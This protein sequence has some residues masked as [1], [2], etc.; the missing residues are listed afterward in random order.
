MCRRFGTLCSIFIGGVYV[1]TFRNAL[2]V[3]SSQAVFICRRFGTL[4]SIFIGGVYVPTFRNALS[5][6]SSQAVFICRRLGTL[7]SIFIGG[8]YVPTFRNTLFH[9]HRRCLYADVSEHSVLSLQLVL[10][11]R[12]FC[13]KLN[14]SL[15][16]DM[17][18]LA[19]QIRHARFIFCLLYLKA[20]PIS[21][22]LCSLYT[23]GKR[24]CVTEE[25][26][27]LNCPF[28]RNVILKILIMP[29]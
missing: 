3:P 29:L 2:S 1:P 11:V 16:V 10:A 9:L 18:V 12:K 25:E 21:F 19:G 23:A 15:L 6:P 7:W 22:D 27:S 13:R 8:V 14:M 4:C 20:T 28:L 5:V 24:F 17:K 26:E